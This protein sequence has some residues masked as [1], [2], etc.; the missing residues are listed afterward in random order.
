MIK[1][2]RFLVGLGTLMAVVAFAELAPQGLLL[3]QEPAT[4]YAEAFE[5]RSFRQDNAL[6]ATLT[7]AAG[8]RKRLKSGG[9]LALVPYPPE[10]FD[11]SFA[12]TAENAIRKIDDLERSYPALRSQL[13]RA[14]G[15]WSRALSFFQQVK[16]GPAATPPPTRGSTLSLRSGVVRDARMTSATANTV[17]L[18]HASGIATFPVEDLSARQVLELNR[19]SSAVQLPL[20]ISRSAAAAPRAESPLTL[21]IEAAGQSAINFCASRLG[22]TPS[23]FSAWTFF[24]VLPALVLVLFLSMVL[25]AWRLR[26]G[27]K[28]LVKLR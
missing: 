21:R 14:R 8:E 26:R 4:T 13:D 22:L 19:N 16:S 27:G 18:R 5:Y 6:Y 17:T 25:N 7:N 1:F 15:K 11:S 12:S 2:P 3:Y 23:S 28:R 24:V 10:S 9:V 20:G